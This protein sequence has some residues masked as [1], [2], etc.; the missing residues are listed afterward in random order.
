MCHVISFITEEEMLQMM[1]CPVSNNFRNRYR[2]WEVTEI[3]T[4]YN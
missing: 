3:V 1:K 2:C 4:T